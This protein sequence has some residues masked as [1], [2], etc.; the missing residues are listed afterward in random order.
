MISATREFSNERGAVIVIVAVWMASAL[1]LVTFVIDVGHWYEHRRHLQL[2]V[3]AAAL[4]GGGMFAACF[5]GGGGDS[6]IFQ[7]AS[8]YAGATGSW[9][10]TQYADP[11]GLSYNGQI[12][13]THKGTV[14]PLYQSRTYADGTNPND[15]TEIQGPCE[16]PDYQFDVKGTEQNV[17]LFFVG[18]SFVP[19]INAH[20]R[21][22][23]QPLGATNPSLPLAAPDVNPRQ[24]GVTFVNEA[25]GNELTGCSG[26]NLVGTS[27]CTF[28]MAKGTPVG[29]LNIWSGPATVPLPSAPANVGVRIGM[30]GQVASCANTAGTRSYACFDGTT[31]SQGLYLIRDFAS[32]GTVTSAPIVNGVWP[33]TSAATCSGSP[34][35]SDVQTG[36]A[37]T[38]PAG[39]Q[40]QVDFGTGATI[41]DTSKY[42]LTVKVTNGQNGNTVSASMAPVTGS[43][44]AT[45]HTWLW[46]AANGSLSL[47]VGAGVQAISFDWSVA[48]ATSPICPRTTGPPTC[49]GGTGT[50]HRFF[51]APTTD[52]SGPIQQLSVTQN[53]A[54]AASL[55]GGTATL[56]VTI[57]ISG[58]FKVNK[59]C[60]SPP[61]G[62]AY[63]CFTYDPIRNVGP[64]RAVL[65]RLKQTRGSQTYTIDCGGGNLRAQ[66]INGCTD[67]YSINTADI[68]PDVGTPPTPPDCADTQT[69]QDTGQIRQGMDARFAPGNPAVC[70]PNTYPN[71]TPGTPGAKRVVIVMIT[72]FSAFNGGGNITVPVVTY[73]A[74]YITGWDNADSSCNGINEPFSHTGHA[75]NSTIGDIWGHF[76]TYVDGAG[77]GT[78]GV[79]DP[80]AL[81]PCVPVLTQ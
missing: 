36:G 5:N 65:L 20:A 8:K 28:A 15:G 54:D 47:D 30:G 69:G 43:Y 38:C 59:A 27:G 34:F 64:D 55:E 21:V 58:N 49:T 19:A 74:F 50:L 75:G 80:T 6:K 77:S 39:V 23:L 10:G 51:S 67:A 32:G 76:I 11:S 16:T 26:T 66:I 25:T 42:G 33:T 62:A 24:V 12:G 57:G 41:P 60:P 61:S 17:P 81:L 63:T 48:K 52:A 40:A 68:C 72:D 7:E 4:G 14:S 73:G 79:C 13:D 46:Q 70:L 9:S 3:D 29:A 45:R 35:F 22:Q 2:Q 37:A 31:N 18:G 1:A 53:G 71:I 78:P 56:N 44:D